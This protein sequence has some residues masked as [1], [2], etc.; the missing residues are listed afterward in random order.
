MDF[1][2]DE[3]CDV[4]VVAGLRADGHDVV[5]IREISPGAEDET[6]LR[7][8]AGQERILLTEDK[9]F[10]EMVVRLGLPAYGILLLRLNPADSTAKLAR[11]RELLL[12][13]ASRLPHSFVVLNENKAR[14]RALP[15]V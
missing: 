5:Y 11:L 1:V 6:V 12:H 10:G 15:V 3:W 9:D 14:V 8:A 7:L 4:P 2:A 13:N